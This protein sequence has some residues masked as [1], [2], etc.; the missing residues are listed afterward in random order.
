[1]ARTRRT[2]NPPDPG[3]PLLLVSREQFDSELA[4]RIEKGQALIDRPIS[5]SDEYDATRSDFYTW[6]EFNRALL[7]RRF[8]T[9]EVLDSY[10]GIGGFFGGPDTLSERI[11]DLRRDIASDVRR[12]QSIREQVPIFEVEVS[13]AANE[14]GTRE[15]TL[16]A[17]ART[18]FIVHGHDEATKLA[19]HGFLRL[20]TELDPVILHNEPDMG[21]TIIEKF[22][23]VGSNAAFAVVILTAD[24]LG[25]SVNET[26]ER[27][28]GRQNVIFEFGFFVGLLGR[29]R[30]A[31][32]YD[33]DVELPSDVAGYLYI[34]RDTH[35]AWKI[36]LA[37]ELR[38]AGI[39]VDLNK[40]L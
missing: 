1:V 32:L 27:A 23:E 11:S 14:S 21:R 26:E 31:V 15:R 34:E 19:V 10:T 8:T 16:S 28:R 5:S 4:D 22:E 30:T 3:P 33:T 13:V 6:D 35:E 7:R 12:L 40:A 29:A 36:S 37:K 9:S 17:E 18:I 24:D 38:A 25:R 20:I 2:S 39:D